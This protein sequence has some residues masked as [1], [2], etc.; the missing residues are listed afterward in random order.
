[1]KRLGHID[2]LRAIA[3]LGVIITHILSYNLGTTLTNNIWNYLHF[4]VP[5]LVFCSGYITYQKYSETRWTLKNTVQWYQKRAVRLIGPY[6]A[7]TILHYGLWYMFP[8]YF[9]GLGLDYDWL[10][11]LFLELMLVTPLYLRLWKTKRP[12]LTFLIFLSS[13]LFLFLKPSLDFRTD[14]WL[15]WSAILLLSFEA[16]SNVIQPARYMSIAILA[17]VVFITG[18]L[19]LPVLH[20]PLTLTLH[21]YPPDIFYLSYGIWIGSMLLL[22]E[23]YRISQ[24][25]HIK[26]ILLWLSK[27]SYG[28]F[29]AHYI[30]LDLIIT[31][32][33]YSGK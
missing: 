20:Q 13:I 11:I 17:F 4:V 32:W 2:Y 12:L 8:K 18:N 7:W 3:I 19:V 29:F 10:P 33:R 21:K 28:L 1:M 15:P 31:L 16:A 9:S 14:M 23:P 5:M 22:M 24:G 6:A 25:K 30:I 26:K 27:N